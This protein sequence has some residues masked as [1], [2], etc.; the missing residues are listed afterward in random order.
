MPNTPAKQSKVNF[1]NL[2]AGYRYPLDV[3]AHAVWLYLRFNLSFRDVEDLLAERGI[4]VTYETI[5]QWCLTFGPEFSKTLHQRRDHPG[6]NWYLDIVFLKIG[7]ELRYL[8]RAVDQDGEVLD[9]L[10]QEYRNTRAAKR[11]F[12]KMLSSRRIYG[13]LDDPEL[14]T[15]S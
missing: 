8:W 11:F 5:R 6:D 14:F 4:I 15:T 2:Y 12:R 10:V 1:P 3:I 7:G 13:I 9:I